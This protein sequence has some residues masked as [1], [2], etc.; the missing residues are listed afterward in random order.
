MKKKWLAVLLSVL[1]VMIPPVVRA[2]ESETLS[3]ETAE[4]AANAQS[5]CLIEASSGR[6]LYARQED[7]RM[8]PASMTKM[9]GLL[10][11]FEQQ[12]GRASCRERV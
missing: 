3:Q 8:Y 7:K 6:Q 2:A 1:M 11:I 10:L 9:M 12:I 5:V 4:L